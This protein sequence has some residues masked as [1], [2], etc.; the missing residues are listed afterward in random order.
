MGSGPDGAAHREASACPCASE[1][2]VTPT[3]LPSL[4]HLGRW[5]AIDWSTHCMQPRRSDLTRTTDYSTVTGKVRSGWR[6][7]AKLAVLP[8]WARR[9]PSVTAARC[10]WPRIP[11]ACDSHADTPSPSCK[12][13]A[14]CGFCRLGPIGRSVR[15]SHRVGQRDSGVRARA[16]QDEFVTYES[17]HSARR[18][19]STPA[20]ANCCSPP[21]CRPCCPSPTRA[22]ASTRPGG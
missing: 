13:V 21:A 10:R 9:Q 20:A 22:P 4:S 5:P 19:G 16:C 17:V 8:A 6:H 12:N 3:I 2:A 7:A 11:A 15:S 1:S 14:F 18:A